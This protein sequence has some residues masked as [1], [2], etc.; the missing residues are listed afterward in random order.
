MV[1]EPENHEIES[2]ERYRKGEIVG[3]QRNSL[4]PL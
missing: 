3:T 1:L 2:R 4:Q